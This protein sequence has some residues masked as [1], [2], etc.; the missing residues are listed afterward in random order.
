M[1]VVPGAEEPPAPGPASA[2]EPLTSAEAWQRAWPALIEAVSLRDRAFAGVVR[3]CRPLQA[4]DSRLVI[5][6]PYKFH[7]DKLR[8]PAKA[9]LLEAASSTLAAGPRAVSA[10]LRAASAVEPAGSRSG[11]TLTDQVLATFS[12][13]RVTSTR[14]L[15]KANDP[16]GDTHG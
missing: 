4:D 10:E 7:L 6:A 15:D 8:D 12:G 2:S 16:P 13:S 5:E 1:P 11:P 3:G 9:P 14:L